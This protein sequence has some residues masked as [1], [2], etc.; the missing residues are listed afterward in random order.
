MYASI[1]VA[2][3]LV[4]SPAPGVCRAAPPPAPTAVRS[5]LLPPPPGP[6]PQPDA[7]KRLEPVAVIAVDTSAAGEE[8]EV[9]GQRLVGKAEAEMQAINVGK[10]EGDALPRLVITVS[11]LAGDSLGWSYTI[12]I[13]HADKAPIPG[14]SF[15]G[16]CVDCTENELVDR[17]GNDT[18]SLLPQLHAY[19]AN[20]NAQIDA[21]Q[22]RRADEER[23]RKEEEEQRKRES[24]GR[25]RDSGPGAADVSP[26]HPLC[27]AGI[28][29]MAGGVVAAGVGLGLMLSPDK[30]DPSA[31]W[32]GTTTRPPGYAALG[33]GGAALL[34]GVALF[35]VGHRRS[36]APRTTLAP[37]MQRGAVGLMWTGR[38]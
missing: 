3:S 8:G 6:R 20:F 36:R 35:V 18:R 28:G 2:L 21:E 23:R 17:V 31:A 33:V 38:F 7:P 16:Q 25:G 5:D 34:T 22:K 26:M 30:Y 27:K 37:A 1:L 29:L 4:L 12:E 24:G 11:A 19:I 15:R 13:N 9:L 14:G 10:G 32:E